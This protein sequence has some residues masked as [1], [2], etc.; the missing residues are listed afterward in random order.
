MNWVSRVRKGDVRAIARLITMIE[1]R[2]LEAGR[3]LDK[4]MKHVGTARRI[5]FTGPPGVG[6]STLVTKVAAELTRRRQKV[7]VLAVDPTSPFTGGALLGDRVRMAE[8][9]GKAYIRS[10]AT[11]GTLGGISGATMD[12]AD[13]LDAAGYR[14]ILIETVGVGQQEIEVSRYTDCV[15]LVVSPESGDSV[16]MLKAGILEA[17]DLIVVNKSDRQGSDRIVFD[18]EN[19]LKLTRRGAAKVMK[20]SASTGSGVVELIRAM[21]E[22]VDEAV[23]DGRFEKRRDEVMANRIKRSCQEHLTRRFQGYNNLDSRVAESVDVVRRRGK[24]LYSEAN[25]ILEEYYGTARKKG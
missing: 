6:K 7:A 23:K 22:F 8:L 21:D 4:L 15:V 20:T 19:T 1:D 12:A 13:V 18:I 11:R 14:Y 3:I 10:M 16:Q 5:G 25:K 17:A 24:G 9:E 2:E